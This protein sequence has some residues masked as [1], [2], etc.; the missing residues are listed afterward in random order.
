MTARTNAD[1][2]VIGGGILGASIAW[3]LARA[4]ITDTVVV[5]RNEVA[6]GA[7]AYTAGLISLARTSRDA[8]AMVRCTLDAVTELEASLGHSVGFRRTGTMRVAE[9]GETS[10]GLENMDRQLSSTGI[11]SRIIDGE[12]AREMVP[13]LDPAAARSVLH[14]AEDGYVDGHMLTSAY[15]RAARNA[16]ATLWTQTSAF[17]VVRSGERI[18]GVETTRGR[19]GCKWLVGAAGTWAGDVLRWFGVELGATPLRSHYWLSAPVEPRWRD[20]PVVSLPDACTYLRREGAGLLVGIQESVSR[21]FDARRLPADMSELTLTGEEDW[22][23]LANHAPRIRR[24]FPD[25][26]EL[27]YAHHIAG[28]TTY[29]PDGELL[30]G[31]FPGVEGLFLA[32]GCC[33]KGVSV[34]GGVGRIVA[35]R[36]LGNSALVDLDRLRPERFGTDEPHSEAFVARCVDA[37]ANKGRRA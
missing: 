24:C 18:V 9:T 34:S 31:T 23:L 14:I 2:V 13:W 4:G 33:G 37:R 26:D 27:R 22:E 16:G 20:I 12:S 6:S 35:D 36:I 19:I 1:V 10:E 29:T 8:L 25:F 28:L 17:S 32:G 7:T 30:L 21:A 5:E 11:E 3:H 15:M